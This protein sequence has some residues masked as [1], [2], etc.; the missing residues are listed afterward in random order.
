[1][2]S[3]LQGM[4][5]FNNTNTAWE[6]KVNFIDENNVMV[7]YDTS[8]RCCEDAGWYI[9]DQLI[10]EIPAGNDP[11]RDYSGYVF[12]TEYFKEFHDGNDL[13]IVV[14]KL[15]NGIQNIYLHLFN[16]HNGFYSHGF[17]MRLPGEIL[18]KGNL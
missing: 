6:N 16:C 10:Q 1:M 12:D 17:E 4:K 13:T 14:F 9:R 3:V 7:G 8:Q 5:I 15:T 2:C 11:E 18:K